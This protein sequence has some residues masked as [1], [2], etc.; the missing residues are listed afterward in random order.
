MSCPEDALTIGSLGQIIVSPT[1]CNLCGICEKRC[2]IGVIEIFNE[3][4]YVCDLCGGNPRCADACTEGAI[5][6]EPK[7]KLPSL[8][9]FKKKSVKL[10]PSQK[11]FLYL[12]DKGDLLR[13]KWRKNID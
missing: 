5:V 12:S 11:R 7:G 8:A 9:A 13:K 1:V 4:V 6:F 2:P 10:N 3:I